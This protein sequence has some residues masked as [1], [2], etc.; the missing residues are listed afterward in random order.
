MAVA[1]WRV[2]K[3][4]DKNP[5]RHNE[6]NGAYSQL[7]QPWQIRI[8]W[9]AVILLINSICWLEL[10]MTFFWA[11]KELCAFRLVVSC[12]TMH[13]DGFARKRPTSPLVDKPNM[14]KKLFLSFVELTNT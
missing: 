4:L 5:S 10:C 3:C 2:K 1:I 14:C 9:R 6:F 12:I 7:I 8:E 13:C 11:E